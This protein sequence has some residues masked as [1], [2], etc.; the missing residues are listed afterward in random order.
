MKKTILIVGVITGAILLAGFYKFNFTNDGIYIKDGEGR[1][2]LVDGAKSTSNNQ[3]GGF[4][5]LRTKT[6]KII[7]VTETHPVGQ[8]ISSVAITTKK[9]KENKLIQLDDI[10]P[11]EKIELQDL[12]NDGFEELYLF[13][14]SVGSGSGGDF[15]AYT[16]DND[17]RLVKCEKL[18]LDH[19]E[20]LKGGLFE[21]YRGHIT[22]SF[23]KDMLIMVFPIYKE[24]DANSKPTGGTKKVSYT[25]KKAK[26][27]IKKT[28]YL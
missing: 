24:N 18:K 2:I 11:I 14:R 22:L 9:F 1:S 15:Y 26:F 13:T 8:S 20:Y 28:E 5:E 4:K 16:S 21:G 19:K 17:E 25:L 6:G 27:S 3:I 12:D 10:D 7:I 23:D